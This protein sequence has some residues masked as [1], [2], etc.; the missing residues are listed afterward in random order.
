MAGLSFAVVVLALFLAT[1]WGVA[2]SIL[3]L[4]LRATAGRAE[5]TRTAPLVATFPWVAGLVLALGAL[6]PGDAHGGRVLA[7]HCLESMPAWLHLCPIHPEQ[8]GGLALPG[9]ALVAL[10]MPGRVRAVW[11]LVREPIGRGGSGQPRVLDLPR[12]VS[13]LHGWLRPTLVVDRSLW[14]ALTSREREAVLAHEGAHL[15]RRDPLV[16]MLLRAL[17]TVA[18]RALA[19]RT[20]RRWL[21]RAERCADLEAARVLGDPLAVAAALLRC[22]H[23]GA[24]SPAWAIAWTGGELRRRIEALVGTSASPAPAR[25]DVRMIDLALGALLVVLGLAATPW[26]HHPLEHLLNLSL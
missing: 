19:D 26:V 20:A 24:R 11:A 16:L 22:A 3:P 18:P 5:L 9:I 10:L 7:C 4:W 12:R 21:D 8:A 14:Q 17:L 6:P 23:L 15:K 1:S 2:A 13:L 25:P